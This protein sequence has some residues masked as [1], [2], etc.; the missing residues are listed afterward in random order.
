MPTLKTL[1]V[2]NPQYKDIWKA[3]IKEYEKDTKVTLP[4]KTANTNSLGVR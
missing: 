2:A 1:Q 4:S 3:A